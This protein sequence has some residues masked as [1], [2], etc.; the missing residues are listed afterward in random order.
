[1]IQVYS[2][3]A[4][5]FTINV[6]FELTKLLHWISTN[7][8]SLSIGKTKC[9]LFQNTQNQIYNHE[10]L[11]LHV[12][13]IVNVDHLTFLGTGIDKNLNWKKYK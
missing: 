9:M 10:K 11:V 7:K 5:S 6:N 1:M 8:L 13:K 3:K 12:D 2:S 4:S